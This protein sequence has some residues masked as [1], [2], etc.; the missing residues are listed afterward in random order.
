MG[1]SLADQLEQTN[2]LLDNIGVKPTTAVVDLGFRGIDEDVAP[3]NVSHLGKF[4]S[5]TQE[6]K[7]WFK[8]CSQTSAMDYN[9]IEL[10][11]GLSWILQERLCNL[12]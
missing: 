12:F 10:E 7:R 3:V 9:E 1:T 6:K 2:S 5:L 8:L 11:L 4:K